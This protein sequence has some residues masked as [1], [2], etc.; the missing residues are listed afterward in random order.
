MKQPRPRRLA[1]ALLLAAALPLF[2]AAAQEAQPATDPPAKEAPVTVREVPAPPEPAETAEP[3]TTTEAAPPRATTRRTVPAP[4]PL[5]APAPQERTVYVPVP[6]QTSPA[7][8][9]S[10]PPVDPYA[11][12]PV[13]DPLSTAAPEVLPATPGGGIDTVVEVEE[14]TG[15][16]LTPLIWLA[17]GA[18]L[19]G[20][21]VY[22]LMRRRRR[23]TLVHHSEGA[24]A[25][26]AAAAPAAEP[27]FRAPAEPVVHEPPEVVPVAAAAPAAAAAAAVDAGRPW[28]DLRL[29]P[30]RAGISGGEA[31][32]EFALD[33]ANVGE[34]IARDVHISTW[35]SPAAGTE[36][37][38]ALIERPA[39]VAAPETELPE[40]T[41]EPGAGKRIET[42]VTLPVAGLGRDSMI[43]VV[44]AEARYRLPDG[45]E[46]RTSAS[47]AV[48]V[49]VDEELASFALDDPS[50]LHEGVEARP[51]GDVERV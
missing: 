33:V 50:G 27:L 13:G 3:A 20:L 2:A 28:L 40:V 29:H 8:S 32:V 30:V 47:F 26:A 18:L 44:V 51:L 15:P 43:P 42:E 19:A 12:P 36:M 10:L 23:D 31:R 21:L 17:A 9:T 6:V 4:D 5:P 34:A 48:G 45:S 38:Q 24:H 49:P 7:P 35:M 14:E 41:I 1:A 16:N 46:A 11:L 22:L 37:E 25:R 39:A